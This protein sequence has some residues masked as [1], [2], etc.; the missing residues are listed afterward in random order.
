M[1]TGLYQLYTLIFARATIVNIKYITLLVIYTL[2][3]FLVKAEVPCWD[4]QSLPCD[5]PCCFQATRTQAAIGY[6]DD[7]ISF[8]AQPPKHK[9]LKC[10]TRFRAVASFAV[11][12]AFVNDGSRSYD[13]SGVDEPLNGSNTHCIL[14]FYYIFLFRFT[15]F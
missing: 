2:A 5:N 15:P 10:R 7:N 3:G 9:Q 6:Q 1:Q 14:P 4:R 11:S 12:S 13:H 8:A